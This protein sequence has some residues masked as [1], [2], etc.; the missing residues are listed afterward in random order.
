MRRQGWLGPHGGDLG[1]SLQGMTELLD[2]KLGQ[3][4]S[5]KA[6]G[7]ARGETAS[8]PSNQMQPIQHP[9]RGGELGFDHSGVRVGVPSRER[10][11]TCK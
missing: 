9:C 10:R 3:P 7:G 5:D 4:S 1:K 2:H 8:L 6:E 11:S